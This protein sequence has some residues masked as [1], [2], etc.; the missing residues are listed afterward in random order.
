MPRLGRLG[1]LALVFLCHGFGL[2][3][4]RGI[5]TIL[6]RLGL[7][8][9]LLPMLLNLRILSG[10][11]GSILRLLGGS[12]GHDTVIMFRMLK[13]ILGHDAVA[14][15]IGVTGQLQIFLV[16]MAGRAADFDFGPGGIVGAIG[17]ETTAAA[18]AAAAAATTIATMLRPAAASARAFHYSP[19]WL[20]E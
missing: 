15:G 16:D 6:R 10:L 7:A 2:G 12:G 5:A 14:A 20:P 11:L 19:S 4:G 8:L 9:G 18:I 3:K 1:I 17:V 13:V